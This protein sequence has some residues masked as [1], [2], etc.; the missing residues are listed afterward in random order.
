MYWYKKEQGIMEKS[1][2]QLYELFRKR[3]ATTKEEIIERVKRDYK[4]VMENSKK[5]SLHSAAYYQKLDELYCQFINK[6]EDTILFTELEDGWYYNYGID[7]SGA[8]LWVIHADIWGEDEE[9]NL[10]YKNDQDFTLI[11]VKTKM[12]TVDK[13]AEVY[14]VEKG[15]IRQWIRRGKLRNAV[16]Y[17]N[18]WKIP[19]LTDPPRRGYSSASYRWTEELEDLPEEYAFL[20]QFDLVMFTQSE[21]DKSIFE[22]AFC[23][24]KRGLASKSIECDAKQREKIEMFMIAHPQISYIPNFEECVVIDLIKSYQVEEQ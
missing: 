9:G 17:G 20:N 18:E 13:Y 19:E 2:K 5:D 1:M 8:E 21:E 4:M 7:Y 15:T 3:H 10:D 6:I 14:G 23:N 24:M 11:R 16:K 12:L 22:I